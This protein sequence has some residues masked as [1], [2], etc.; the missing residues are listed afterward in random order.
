MAAYRSG[1]RAGR[2]Q[3]NEGR[4]RGRAPIA[5]IGGNEVGGKLQPREV[6]ADHSEAVGRDIDGR[7]LSARR[8]ELSGLAAGRGTE[9]DHRFPRTSPSSRAGS[10]AAKSCTHQRPS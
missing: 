9:I 7:H 6:L 8:R 10:V 3:Q 4:G 2:V 1:G 5:R